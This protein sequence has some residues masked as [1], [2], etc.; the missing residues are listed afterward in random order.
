L[1]TVRKRVPPDIFKLVEHITQSIVTILPYLSNRGVG[2]QN[3]VTIQNTA[4]DY[5]PQALQNYLKL[6]RAYAELHPVK[7]GKT[8]HQLLQE[9]LSLLDRAM[10][11][12]V[13]DAL[14][15]DAQRLL[16]HG[17]FLQEK[18]QTPDDWL[19]AGRQ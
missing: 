4:L 1:T 15:T 9:Q 16:V 19:V 14:E 13:T 6:P 11:E 5:L 12:I 17:R 10:D 18:F 2:D 3:V 7:D 8:A